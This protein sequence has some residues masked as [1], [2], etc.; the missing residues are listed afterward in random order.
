MSNGNLDALMIL[1][2]LA[3]V[4]GAIVMVYGHMELLEAQQNSGFFGM[5]GDGGEEAMKWQMV[6][7]GGLVA[8]AVGGV[9]TFSGAVND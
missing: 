8:A 2:V 1:G 9:L 3:L 4:A 5:G 7:L 6:R